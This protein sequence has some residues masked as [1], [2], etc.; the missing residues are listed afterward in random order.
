MMMLGHKL[1]YGHRE[2]EDGTWDS[3]CTVCFQTIMTK[4]GESG[5]ESDEAAHLCAHLGG[6]P[7]WFEFDT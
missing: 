4:N 3:I 1:Y 5:L 2:N 7:V 6:A